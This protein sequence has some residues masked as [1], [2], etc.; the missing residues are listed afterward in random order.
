ML[1][2]SQGTHYSRADVKE[3]AGLPRSERGGCWYTGIV[4]HQDE[5]LIFANV[6]IAG[7][8]GHDY[9]NR[10]EGACLRWSH[11]TRSHLKWRSVQQLL[12]PGRR[13]HV[14]WRTEDRGMFTYAGLAR[15]SEV[16]D[17]SPVEILWSFETP[18]E[19]PLDSPE[20]PPASTYR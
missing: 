9:R 3:V 10:W 14:F 12:Q 20:Q 17:R 11:Q 13:I 16:A 5:F 19:P 8:T 18:E 2:F 1:S 7:R 4:R 6:G 15:A